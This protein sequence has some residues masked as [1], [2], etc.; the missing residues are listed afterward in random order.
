MAQIVN[1]RDYRHLKVN[2]AKHLNAYAAWP[3]KQ[4]RFLIMGLAKLAELDYG[5][6]KMKFPGGL[7]VV[8]G[9]IVGI[10]RGLCQAGRGRPDN[11]G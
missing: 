7:A 1:L 3:T 5:V 11:V 4:N 10:N 8:N 2:I 6:K 9:Q